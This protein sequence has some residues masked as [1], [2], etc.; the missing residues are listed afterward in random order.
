MCIRDRYKYGE[1][2]LAD[3]YR[4]MVMDTEPGVAIQ[5][6]QSA[7]IV[8]IDEVENLIQTTVKSNRSTGVQLVG[9]QLLEKMAEQKTL[10]SSHYTPA[11][12]VLFNKGKTIFDSY[13]ATCHGVK[14]LGTPTGG[15]QLIAPAFSGS[16]RIQ[17]HPEYAV[18]TLLHGLT[19]SI[20]GKEYEGVMIAMNT[21][22][23]EWVASIVSYIRNEFGNKGSFV[24]P[25]FVAQIRKETIARKST[26]SFDE[27]ISEVPKALTPQDTWK[28]TASSTALQ[29][30]G[31]TK[32]P[33]Y[34]LSFKGWETDTKQEAGMWF[35]I[36]LPKDQNLT[37]VQF[38]SGEE[39]FPVKYAVSI[40]QNGSS[41]TQVALQPGKK[42]MN[43][44]RWK[45]KQPVRF[46]K[47]ETL[48]K[49]DQPWAMKKLSLYAR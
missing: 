26:Y 18:K 8:H 36:A 24:D 7:F 41:W 33:S 40:S 43:T 45:S 44:A 2:S 42:G 38:D 30:V 19:G 16:P 13:C 22:D 11:Q 35:Q 14:G 15:G 23:D 12:L 39:K 34:A 46:L 4:V 6:L 20:E 27:L 31:S 29:G 37:E 9:T 10:A 28:V 49:A 25:E 5:A 17:G 47:I 48:Q 1:K 32:D 3:D 21:N